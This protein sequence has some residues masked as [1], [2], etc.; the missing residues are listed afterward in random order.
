MLMQDATELHRLV[1]SNDNR[2]RILLAEISDFA[3]RFRQGKSPKHMH[4]V[5]YGM[6]LRLNGVK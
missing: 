3:Q 5:T 1:A 6:W 2:L 4:A